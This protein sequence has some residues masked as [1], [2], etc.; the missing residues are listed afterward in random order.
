MEGV[1]NENSAEEM[2]S[3][4]ARLSGCAVIV[5]DPGAPFNGVAPSRV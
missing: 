2:G 4:G 5:S 1:G 3:A